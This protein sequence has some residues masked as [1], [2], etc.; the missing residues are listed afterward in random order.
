MKIVIQRVSKA[1][2]VVQKK[3]IGSIKK[4]LL[5][6][7]GIKKGDSEEEVDW[8]VKKILRMRIFEDEEGKM[9]RSVMDVGGSILL[10][11]NFTLYA[12][13][14]QGNRPGFSDAERPGKAEKLYKSMIE[15]MKEQSSL[16]VATGAFG[17]NMDVKLTND[18]PVTI[19]LEK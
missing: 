3:E 15:S 6:L 18:G 7:V 12:D 13:A 9:N 11:P 8:L 10:V 5:L 14:T 2:V 19:I 17:A 1:S 4:G 16:K